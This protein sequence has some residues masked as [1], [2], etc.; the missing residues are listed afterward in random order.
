[1]CNQS[2]PHTHGHF[3][4][5]PFR[6]YRH[7]SRR[8]FLSFA[9]RGAFA[10]LTKVGVARETL[11]IA[12]GATT[13]GRAAQH[14]A[15]YSNKPQQRQRV[16]QPQ[17]R[18]QSLKAQYNQRSSTPAPPNPHQS[19]LQR[20]RR[21]QATPAQRSQRWPITASRLALSMLTS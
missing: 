4:T 7:I 15:L 16:H 2:Q 6:R 9:G 11:A 18:H 14:R 12:I 20:H 13:L 1:M 21:Q 3:V 10:L 17:R 19:R 5:A 8:T